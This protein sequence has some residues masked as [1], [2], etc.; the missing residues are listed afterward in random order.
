M[1]I[2]TK[3]VWERY[4][5]RPNVDPTKQDVMAWCLSLG[6]YGGPKIIAYALTIREAHLKVRRIIKELDPEAALTYGVRGK[7]KRK[8]FD[9]FKAKKPVEKK[10]PRA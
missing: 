1:A 8:K 4:G 3:D 7:P 5:L 9:R 10:K 6:R 2:L